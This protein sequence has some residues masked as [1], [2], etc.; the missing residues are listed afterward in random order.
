MINK[1]I[2]NK[3]LILTFDWS[4]NYGAT[5]QA[6]A[7]QQSIKR[8]GIKADVLRYTPLRNIFDDCL[9]T[10]ELFRKKYL[11]RTKECYTE[12]ELKN[13]LSKLFA[14]LNFILHL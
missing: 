6:Y 13:I 10:R 14:P 11:S 12:S 9:D 1:I 7:L 8:L 5:L 4:L 3:F 2:K